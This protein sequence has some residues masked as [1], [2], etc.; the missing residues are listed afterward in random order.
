M[1]SRWWALM[2][3]VMAGPAAADDA[4]APKTDPVVPDP[5]KPSRSN[6]PE[7]PSTVPPVTQRVVFVPTGIERTINFISQLNRDC[8]SLGSTEYRVVAK[9]E[10]GTVTFEVGDNF[11]SYGI[12]TPLEHCN[13]QKS[14]GLYTRFTSA[15]GYVG[16]DH[17]DVLYLL[18]SAA[19]LEVKYTVVVR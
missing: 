9:P 12:N 6:P 17:L 13:G 1:G 2:F 4:T 7:E 11:A 5:A 18:P 10:H 16:Q 19:A 3:L 15:E 14:P 8:S